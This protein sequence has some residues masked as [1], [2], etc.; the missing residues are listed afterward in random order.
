MKKSKFNHHTTKDGQIFLYNSKSDLVLTIDQLLLDFYISLENDENFIELEKIHPAYYN[1]LIT[2][3]YIL[4][5]E[6]NEYEIVR[7]EMIKVNQEDTVFK[8]II[9]PTMNCNFKCWY[10]YEDHIKSSRMPVSVMKNVV[11]IARDKILNNK[12]I[13]DFVMDWFGGEPLLQYYPVVDPLIKIVSEICRENNVNFYTSFTT[14]GYL[15]NDKMIESF[16][17]NNITS[18]QITLDGNEKQHDKVRYVSKKKGSYKE[19]VVNIIKLVKSGFEVVL[20][21]NYDQDTLHDLDEIINDLSEVKN[22]PNLSMSLQKVWQIEESL[23][24]LHKKSEEKI[25]ESGLLVSEQGKSRYLDY[26]CYADYEN[27]LVINYNGDIFKCTA[28]DFNKENSLGNINDIGEVVLNE[29][30]NIRTENRFVNKPCMEC[31]IF[32]I[33]GGGCS[34]VAYDHY[35]L[36]KDY[37]VHD[38][39]EDTKN[40]ILNAKIK[41]LVELSY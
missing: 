31:K 29:K 33:C 3:G 2:G 21:I 12:N 24:E 4:P 15:I 23:G 30:K 39:N 7:D 8:L 19:I 32:P 20:R 36:D 40:E 38:Y 26:H 35:K 41:K 5:K 27:E 25:A 14:N 34:E 10:C 13:K 9:N 37:C 16:I 1:A 22:M 18:F 17:E 6:V 28:R 11:I